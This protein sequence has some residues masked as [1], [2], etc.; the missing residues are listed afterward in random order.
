MN[1]QEQVNICRSLSNIS[2]HLNAV[3]HMVED[4]Q[5]N[6]QILR[7]IGAIQQALRLI[8]CSL[9]T[10]QV[11]ESITVIQ[12]TPNPDVQKNE[13]MRV[14]ELYKETIRKQ[15]FSYEVKL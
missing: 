6:K 7:Q 15:I 14:Q 13:L 8:R 5:P 11:R 3:T 2:V 12:N 10:C 9:I 1:R 4:E